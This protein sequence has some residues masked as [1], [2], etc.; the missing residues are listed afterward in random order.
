MDRQRAAL[1]SKGSVVSQE[2]SNWIKE[3]FISRGKPLV[4]A[5]EGLDVDYLQSGLL[6]SL[7][8]VEFVAAIEDHFGMQFSESEM[9]DPRFS[10]IGGMAELIGAA[11]NR[12]ILNRESQTGD[13]LDRASKAG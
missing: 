8:I 11:L 2:I 5:Q 9:Q 4:R 10:T 1:P 12:E 7:E 3:W 13:G 6:T